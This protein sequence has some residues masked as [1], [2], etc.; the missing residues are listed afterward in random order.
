M[1]PRTMPGVSEH[2]PLLQHQ[3]VDNQDDDRKVRIA[4]CEVAEV[5]D[6]S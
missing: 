3:E 5:S 1:Q 2:S 6:V 4:T